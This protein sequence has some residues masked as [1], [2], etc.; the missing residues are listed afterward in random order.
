[1]TIFSPLFKPVFKP[2]FK[3]V[4]KVPS[5]SN[6]AYQDKLLAIGGADMVCYYPL[7]ELT[8]SAIIDLS[9]KMNDGTYVSTSL[10]S[11]D[12]PSGTRAPFF[13][14]IASVGNFPASDFNTLFYQEEFTISVWMRRPQ[15]PYTG[16]LSL[17]IVKD[18][19]STNNIELV[20]T[21]FSSASQIE[22]R[23]KMGGSAKTLT[24]A[25]PTPLQDYKRI[26]ITMSK[27]NN[28]IRYYL[29]NALSVTA[30][31]GTY[32]GTTWTQVTLCA[33]DTGSG[34]AAFSII[35]PSDLIIYNREATADEVAQ[36]VDA[37]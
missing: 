33:R 23:L 15:D 28:R 2:V 17:S 3:S 18:N 11:E 24:K 1:M 31:P 22:W 12:A 32:T 30:T 6:T 29:G 21:F 37:P 36:M 5:S 35:H 7:N 9:G 4:F 25:N 13:D 19:A 10:D 27:S 34:P 20:H 26:T 14:G 8:G 16:A